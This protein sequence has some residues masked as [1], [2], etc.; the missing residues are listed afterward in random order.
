MYSYTLFSHCTWRPYKTAC[1]YSSQQYWGRDNALLSR[2]LFILSVKLKYVLETGDE[3]CVM[4]NFQSEYELRFCLCW[5][6]MA[7]SKVIKQETKQS[8]P[9]LLFRQCLVQRVTAAFFTL[10][11]TQFP[12]N[13]SVHSPRLILKHREYVQRHFKNLKTF[14]CCQL[15]ILSEEVNG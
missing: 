1:W 6:L 2:L 7:L 9:P 10:S 11:F 13:M 15:L 8:R 5:S 3:R 14:Q 12:S 4:L